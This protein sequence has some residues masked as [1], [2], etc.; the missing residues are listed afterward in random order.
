MKKQPPHPRNIMNSPKQHEHKEIHTQA[1]HS[2]KKKKKKC[3]KDKEKNLKKQQEKNDS[4]VLRISVRLTDFCYWKQ[5]RPGAE[6]WMAYSKSWKKKK[7]KA[8]QGSYIQKNVSQKWRWNKDIFNEKI[9]QKTPQR[10][11]GQQTHLTENKRNSFGLKA[12]DHS[13]WFKSIWGRQRVRNYIIIWDNV[14]ACIS[15][16]LTD[17]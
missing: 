13:W 10:I 5:W 15:P 8:N 11:C 16:F 4:I 6:L 17:F 12:N 14:N 9:S 1:L 3:W 7:K 2:K